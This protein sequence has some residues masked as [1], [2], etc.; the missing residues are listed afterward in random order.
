MLWCGSLRVAATQKA[1][2]QREIGKQLVEVDLDFPA[3]CND[4][5]VA[6]EAARTLGASPRDMHAFVFGDDVLPPGFGGN[7]HPATLEALDQV[8]ASLATRLQPDDLLLFVASN[9]GIEEGLL[10]SG[11]DEFDD[12]MSIL[13]PDHLDR[14]LARM[15]GKQALILATCYSGAFLPLGARA[16]RAV[17]ASCDSTTTYYLGVSAEDVPHSLFLRMLLCAWTGTPVPF[18]SYETLRRRPLVEAFEHTKQELVTLRRQ[19]PHMNGSIT[20]G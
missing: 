2:T 16:D 10:T 18:G 13:T 14:C 8:S 17:L 1:T 12:G 20:L 4:L 15:P 7:C 11:V 3:S 5:A 19:C 9:H 6:V